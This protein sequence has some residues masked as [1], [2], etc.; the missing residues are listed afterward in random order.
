MPKSIP[1][2]PLIL[3]L[4]H[5]VSGFLAIGALITGFWVYNTY[6]GR[7]GTLKLPELYDAQGVHGTFGLFFLISF[8]GLAIYSL[9]WGSRRLLF[10][11]FWRRLWHQPGQPVWWVNLQRLV[12]SLMLLAAL[13]AVISGRMMQESWLPFGE[14]HHLAYQAHLLGW[15]VLLIS[16]ML[17]LVINLK[18][19]GVPLLV[20]MVQWGYR[21]EES[22][23]LWWQTLRQRFRR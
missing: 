7:F 13:L 15:L 16:L 11:N 14:T 5:G 9:Y 18:V 3:R 19:G 12:N 22:P 1:Y 2:Q 20:S 10:P 8:T 23:A 21:P 17:H 6:D 4:V